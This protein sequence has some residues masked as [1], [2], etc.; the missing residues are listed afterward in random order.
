[1]SVLFIKFVRIFFQLCTQPNSPIVFKI[2]RSDV[3]TFDDSREL[4]EN[5]EI[6]VNDFFIVF[7][8]N[9]DVFSHVESI[10]VSVFLKKSSLIVAHRYKKL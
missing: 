10:S 1:M 8:G 4:L 6:F 9:L 5:F 7:G 2:H 3:N